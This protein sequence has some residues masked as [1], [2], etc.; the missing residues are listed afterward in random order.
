CIV[1]GTTPAP[2]GL[3]GAGV[4]V[5]PPAAP[6]L[7]CTDAVGSGVMPFPDF[8]VSPAYFVDQNASGGPGPPGLS[9]DNAVTTID[10]ATGA[11]AADGGHIW[12]KQGAYTA[13]TGVTFVTLAPDV[14]LFGGFPAAATGQNGDL[15]Q[16]ARP[17]KTELDGAGRVRHVIGLAGGSGT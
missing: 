11:A 15:A 16:S 8:S 12:I 6:R 5:G 14:S 1:S 3:S 7:H 4:A 10:A 2:T 9:W 17:T 13:P